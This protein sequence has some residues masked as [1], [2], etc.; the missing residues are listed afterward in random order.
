MFNVYKE[1]AEKR[2]ENQE[3]IKTERRR[4]KTNGGYTENHSKIK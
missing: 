2:L 3:D 1:K 4:L